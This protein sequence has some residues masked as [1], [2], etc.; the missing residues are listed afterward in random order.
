LAERGS[1]QGVIRKVRDGDDDLTM[2]TAAAGPAPTRVMEW[3]ADGLPL[4][5]LVDLFLG[6][7]LDSSE[8][9]RREGAHLGR[10]GMPRWPH[11]AA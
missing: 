11:P 5:L 1:L 8:V 10:S 7:R 6:D 3:L 2:K 4:A 9:M